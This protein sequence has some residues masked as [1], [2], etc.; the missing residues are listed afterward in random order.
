MGYILKYRMIFDL[1]SKRILYVKDG[2]EDRNGREVMA[3]WDIYSL[4]SGYIWMW[5]VL[6]NMMVLCKT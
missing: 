4:C 2:K 6:L 5:Y 1:K 3:W